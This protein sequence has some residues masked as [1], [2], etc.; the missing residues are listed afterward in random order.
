LDQWYDEGTV[1]A[2]MK[3]NETVFW[4]AILVLALTANIYRSFAKLDVP[5]LYIIGPFA[6]LAALLWGLL[7]RKRQVE[8]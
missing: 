5:T 3:R 7:V 2:I 6:V 8:I 4:I 1:A